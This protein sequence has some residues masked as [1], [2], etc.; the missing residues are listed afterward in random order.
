[1][2]ARA[3]IPPTAPPKGGHRSAREPA[4]DLRRGL[5]SVR[6]LFFLLHGRKNIGEFKNRSVI[7]AKC[8]PPGIGSFSS[9]SEPP[10]RTRFPKENSFVRL[11]VLPTASGNQQ[12]ARLRLFE[13]IMHRYGFS[14]LAAW[15]KTGTLSLGLKSAG[16]AGERTSFP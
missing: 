7:R 9:R 13:N 14:L 16:W 8:P 11:P 6:A 15:T 3:L 10:E 12:A 4:L 2:T 5:E 1:M